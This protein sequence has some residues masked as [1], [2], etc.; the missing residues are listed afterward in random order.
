MQRLSTTA[1]LARLFKIKNIFSI[2]SD[3]D[4]LLS[5]VGYGESGV[6]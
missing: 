1:A 2:D 3:L 6:Q 5:E 4:H